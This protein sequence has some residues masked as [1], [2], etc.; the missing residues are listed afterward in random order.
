M[1]EREILRGDRSR[2]LARNQFAKMKELDWNYDLQIDTTNTNSFTNAEK[3][4]QFLKEN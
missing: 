3:I 1:E 2:G 4:L